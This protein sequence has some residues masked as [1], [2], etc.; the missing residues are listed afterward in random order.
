MT[1]AAVSASL[2]ILSRGRLAVETVSPPTT[3]RP[4]NLRDAGRPETPPA[5]QGGRPG[6]CSRGTLQC[7]AF[8]AAVRYEGGEASRPPCSPG[9]CAGYPPARPLARIPRPG[10]G[11]RRTACSPAAPRRPARPCTPGSRWWPGACR[12]G[13]RLRTR[14]RSPAARKRRALTGRPGS[15]LQRLRQR[16]PRRQRGASKQAA[17]PRPRRHSAGPAAPRANAGPR[18]R[19]AP[20]P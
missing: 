20:P 14:R 8:S 19:G 1:E 4:F 10:R 18:R 16:G 13:D 2:S 7:G 15:G 9:S 6:G 5:G 17:R 11:P 3:G 12:R